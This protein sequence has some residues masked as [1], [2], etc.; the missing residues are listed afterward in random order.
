MI[1]VGYEQGS[2]YKKCNLY[3]YY[4]HSYE[5]FLPTHWS[6]FLSGPSAD[7]SCAMQGEQWPSLWN[8]KPVGILIGLSSLWK[9][10]FVEKRYCGEKYRSQINAAFPASLGIARVSIYALAHAPHWAPLSLSNVR[11]NLWIISHF[12][13]HSFSL[14]NMKHNIEII[15]HFFVISHFLSKFNILCKL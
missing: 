11:R 7:I 1:L 2:D 3:V 12:I 8:W 15:S 10:Q 4:L 6:F 13:S 5:L 9:F 14:M